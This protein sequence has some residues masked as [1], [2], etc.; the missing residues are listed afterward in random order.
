LGSSK[1]SNKFIIPK[2]LESN[3]NFFIY[4]FFKILK[5]SFLPFRFAL[6]FIYYSV[7]PKLKKLK[8]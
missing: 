2:D 5:F 8:F 7:L 4:A 3:Y 6:N 1:N